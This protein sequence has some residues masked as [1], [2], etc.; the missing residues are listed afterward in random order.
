MI[1]RLKALLTE[2]SKRPQL[3]IWSAVALMVTVLLVVFSVVGT[4]TNWFCTVPCHN[5]HDDNTLAF[6]ASSHVMISCIACHEPLNGTPLDFILMKIEVAPDLI[7]T[8]LG[9]FHLPVNES[10][11]VAFEMP[12][13]QC[14]Q[15][16]NLENRTVTASAGL[17]M[18]HDV[19]AEKHV[20]C[21]SCHNRVAHPEEDIELVLSDKKHEN[22]MVMD[23]CFRCHGLEPEAVAPGACDACHTPDF[24]LVPESHAVPNWF[25]EFGD[26][27][28]HG[29]AAS[30]EAS[31]V[32]AAEVW[33]EEIL[34]EADIA[35]QGPG[36]YE[37]GEL[38]PGYEQTVNTCYTCHPRQFCIDC[39]GVEM[40]HPEGF[41]TN[42]GN[43]GLANP[44]ACAQCHARSEAEAVGT[45]FCSAC[46]HP[47][48]TPDRPW[49]DQ[50]Y[51]PVREGGTA[52]CLT[53]HNPRYCSACH[54]DGPEAAARVMREQLNQ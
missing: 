8:I 25:Q 47:Q 32:A 33:A 46:H 2:R 16:H 19:H 21:T 52:Q 10:Q 36:E 42:H 37:G 30:E 49:L 28:G 6:N 29:M 39:H 41:K 9:T 22:W 14:L 17:I 3:L 12:D 24:N 1:A 31:R 35:H 7:P 27:S 40:P 4:S 53:C 50:H 20:K 23:A 44:A 45:Q 26:S 38:R 18:N 54:V 11:S 43:E 48:S 5:V 13:E 34:S 51:I 15:C